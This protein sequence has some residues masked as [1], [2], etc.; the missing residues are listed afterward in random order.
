MFGSQAVRTEQ[1]ARGAGGRQPVLKRSRVLV[2]PRDSWPRMVRTGI[3]MIHVDTAANGDMVFQFTHSPQYQEVQLTFLRAVSSFNPDNISAILRNSPYHIDSLLQLSEVFKMSGDTQT[4]AD[5]V[6]R[7]LYCSECGF[8]PLFNVTSGSCRLD[9]NRYENRAFFLAL[10]RQIVFVGQRG[11]WRT[12][13]EYARL[14]LALSPEKDP[15]SCLLI[16]DYYALRAREYD[17]LLRFYREWG[18]ARQLAWLPNMALSAAFAKFMLE[19]DAANDAADG[20]ASSSSSSSSAAAAASAA[21]VGGAQDIHAESSAML[22]EALIKFPAFPLILSDKTNA[23][24]HQSVSHHPYFQVNTSEHPSEKTVRLLLVLYVERCHALWKPENV[25][26][27]LQ[28]RFIGSRALN[29]G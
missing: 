12:A 2:T 10:F 1:R 14:L 19:T 7:A 22:Q 23:V 4:A 20:A 25:M 3:Q 29:R 28:V 9:Y 16:V 24:L 21:A 26:T 18:T 5:F 6:E 17:F 13:L 15:L 27:W 11:C 8:H